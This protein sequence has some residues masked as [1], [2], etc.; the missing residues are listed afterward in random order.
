VRVNFRVFAEP[1]LWDPQPSDS[2]LTGILTEIPEAIVRGTAVDAFLF[3]TR[4]SGD[5][6]TFSRTAGG[7]MA[8]AEIN[9]TIDTETMQI[10]DL[11]FVR[12]F[13]RADFYL[14]TDAVTVPPHPEWFEKRKD[15]T[16]TP[17]QAIS[18]HQ[19]AASDDNFKITVERT[20]E[21]SVLRVEIHAQPSVPLV[22]S[23]LDIIPI[24][25]EFTVK[26]VKIHPK[27]ALVDLINLVIFE[28]EADFRLTFAKREDGELTVMA[29]GLHDG[30]PNYEIYVNDDTPLYQF[31]ATADDAPLRLNSPLTTQE[32]PTTPAFVLKRLP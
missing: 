4:F 6:R 32:Q 2:S 16:V 27:E 7:S 29:R 19:L 1:D 12:S 24:A 11:N 31:T 10:R 23:D 18:G 21:S 25:D 20:G 15:D 30:F 3:V 5:N 17:I 13:A 8:Q 9:F 14:F 28:L 22:K 26:G